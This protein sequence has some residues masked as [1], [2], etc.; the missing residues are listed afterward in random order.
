MQYGTT[1]LKVSVMVKPQTD[2]PGA[3]SSPTIFGELMQFLVKPETDLTGVTSSPTIFGELM[4]FLDNIPW[5]SQ[6]PQVRSRQGSSQMKLRLEKSQAENHTG[7]LMPNT[8]P[9]S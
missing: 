4:Q 8:V 3:I 5:Q 2:L 6:L 1:E 7:S 9:D